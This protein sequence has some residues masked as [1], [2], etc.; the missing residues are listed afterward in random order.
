MKKLLIVESPGKIKT[1]TKFLNNE[2]R[3]MSTVGHIKDL[4]SKGLGITMDASG[5]HLEY[6]TIKDKDKVISDIVKA[7]KTS[8]EVYLAPD[9]DREGEIIAWHVEQEINKILPQ[10]RIHRITFN[11]ITKS[12]I[13]EAIKHP[14]VVDMPKVF[15]QQ[16]RRVLDR[17]V[18][19]EVSPI[20]WRKLAKGLSAGR[21]QSVALKIICQREKEV[22]AFK[23]EEYWSIEGAFAHGKSIFNAMLTHIGKK[24]ADLKNEEETKLVVAELKN[25][26]YVIESIVD[27]E[28]IKN[29]V[30]PF[31][32]SSLQ[33]AAANKLGFAVK[34]T[35][36]IAQSMYEGVPLEDPKSP[37]A[38]I[39]YMR[40]DSTRLSQTA[41]D[42]AREFILSEWGKTYLP[43]KPNTY[44]KKEGAQDAHEAIRP[45]E[46]S[47]KPEDIKPYVSA[48]I[49]K[50]YQLIW[51]R[52]VAS[53]MK[54]AIYAQRQVVI[55]ADKYTFK[56]TGSTLTFD[57]FLKA[58]QTEEEDDDKVVKLPNGLKEQDAVSLEKIDPK[59]HFTQPP[60]KFSE[61]SLVKEL[62]KQGIGR[63]STYATII[64]TIQARKYVELDKKRFVP[65][66]LGM[67]V[68]EM[69]DENLPKIM[70]L[71]FTAH[72]E[73]DLDKIAGGQIE[74]DTLLNEFWQSFS[75]DLE[76]FKGQ[77]GGALG[78]KTLEATELDC[79]TCKEKKLVVR[80]G[81]NGS[82]LGCP[83][84]PKC[85]FTSKFERQ[86]DGSI[87]LLE[88][89]DL[90]TLLDE[91]CSK[92]SNPMRL[93]KGRFGEFVSCSGYPECKN[94]KQNVASFACPLCQG[95][96]AERKWRG[97]TL[98]GCQSY[99]KC[100][101]SIFSDIDQHPCPKCKKS[102]YMIKKTDR[103]GK[104]NLICPEDGCKH[105]VS[106]QE[107]LHA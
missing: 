39:T 19:Y 2:F 46:M 64:S 57:G 60:A 82:F 24:P 72:M 9:P 90:P 103:S 11:E 100:K 71:K 75:V 48:E 32:T 68:T 61:A 97:G 105:V 23:T 49:Y 4:P 76:K 20:L 7:A 27:K 81:K 10:D 56:V 85:T 3:V 29:P 101:F 67:K 69:L 70:N 26:N 88:E 74:R 53:Q 8:D 91:A 80:L 62:E 58:Y 51:S 93:M 33:Q 107:E 94:I 44:G 42:G 38:L 17:W 47:L 106:Q 66:D 55:Q 95:T 83:G 79:P 86:D 87:V 73:E 54:P 30:A 25:K 45:I 41:I 34:R 28:R 89:T 104:T 77:T 35:M 59:Q 5:I 65:T 31:I 92:C 36:T 78:K 43:S 16:A 13:T 52:A 99:P 102:L 37:T 15:A 21:V 22:R 1:I 6:E 84:Y 98:W 12:A 14:S 18:G 50:L 63:P 96:V 40:T